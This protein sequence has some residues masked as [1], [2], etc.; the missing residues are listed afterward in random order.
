MQGLR[1][2]LRV[3]ARDAAG[4]PEAAPGPPDVPVREV[5]DEGL[6]PAA[7][8][9]RVVRVQTLSRL[10]HRVGELRQDPAVHHRAPVD[11][12]RAGGCGIEPVRV[13]VRDEERVD[14]PEGQQELANDLVEGLERHPTI[15]PRR[16]VREEEPA[17]RVGAVTIEDLE[18]VDAVAERL[19]HLPAVGVE[20]KSETHDVAVRRSVEVQDPF[21]HQRVEPA[22]R[23][24][25]R[26]GDE[27]GG[28]VPFER[29]DAAPE[30]GVI[31]PLRERHRPRVVPRVDDLG[32]TLRGL[33]A[34]GAVE[35]HLVDAG[36]V[37]IQVAQVPSRELA[38]LAERPDRL[39]VTAFAS[40]DRQR[41]SPITLA[42]QRP[43]D[44][45]LQPV[46]VP[47]VLDVGRVPA[48]RVVDLEQAVL[49]FGRAHVPTGARVVEQGRV[50]SPAERVRVFEG[51]RG[52]QDVPS[53]EVLDDQRVRIFHEDPADE[54]RAELREPPVVAHRLEDRPPLRPADGQILRSERG[55]HVDD[56]G[57][58]F[59]GHERPGDDRVRAFDVLVRGLV[60]HTNQLAPGQGPDHGAGVAQD[61]L[62]ERLP[63]DQP[64]PGALDQ[65]VRGRSIDGR[66][67]VGRKRPGRRR[68]HEQ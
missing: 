16:P 34:L 61:G 66:A 10:T 31:P 53:A 30:L 64:F 50:A 26:L 28:E 41:R 59:H 17:E 6:D 32:D 20:D 63:D 35:R 8:P 48:H 3:G 24:V 13:G 45:V 46:A 65:Q 42:R 15:R 44:V 37:W 39:L 21:G 33:A 47:P 14:V 36:L 9:G 18:R 58:L 2:G 40:P 52:E 43:I 23:L 54:R 19:R 60:A 68:P 7:G 57:S 49:D 29:F 22:P 4:V 25:D 27:V 11:R 5:A 67:L 51:S 1:R 62:A 12:W 38:Q 56:P 55:G